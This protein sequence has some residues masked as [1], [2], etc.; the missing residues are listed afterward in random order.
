MARAHV[1]WMCADT[2]PPGHMAEP[3]VP[4]RRAKQSLIAK[5]GFESCGIFGS[6]GIPVEGSPRRRSG[7]HD[8]PGALRRQLPGGAPA[9]QV[10]RHGPRGHHQ[11][12]CTISRL[13]RVAPLLRVA[14]LLAVRTPPAQRYF[15]PAFWRPSRARAPRTQPHHCILLSE[16]AVNQHRDSLALYVGNDS[17]SQYFAVAENESVGRVKFSALQVGGKHTR[18]L[19]GTRRALPGVLCLT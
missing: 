15:Q 16:W 7:L 14:A 18:R 9:D 6:C 13:A 8:E 10:R 3:E 12:V 1:R 11:I 17:L 2:A 19:T 5:T 4:D